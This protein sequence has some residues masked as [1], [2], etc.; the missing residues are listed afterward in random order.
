MISKLLTYFLLPLFKI[1]FVLLKSILFLDI[2]EIKTCLSFRYPVLFKLGL[3][4]FA[5]IVWLKW[6]IFSDKFKMKFLR[7]FNPELTITKITGN[8]LCPSYL[9]NTY[10]NY[11]NSQ[12]FRQIRIKFSLSEY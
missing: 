5:E 6:Y 9:V 12:E 4:P 7:E 11:I 8:C 2:E 1:T 10:Y 3:L